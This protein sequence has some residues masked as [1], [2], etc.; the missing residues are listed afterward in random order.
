MEDHFKNKLKNH[1]VDWQKEDLLMD[2]EASLSKKK[3]SSKKAWFLLFPLGLLIL[4]I[5]WGNNYSEQQINSAV[6]KNSKV[7]AEKN[8]ALK[9]AE[10][11]SKIK[12][13]KDINPPIKRPVE[14]NRS[15]DSNETM[16][17]KTTPSEKNLWKTVKNSATKIIAQEKSRDVKKKPIL[18]TE[19]FV[20]VKVINVEK[21]SS[22]SSK[23]N[24]SSDD[25]ILLRKQNSG[26]TSSEDNQDISNEKL[27]THQPITLNN[28]HLIKSSIVHSF[29]PNLSIEH[30]EL[31]ATTS[32]EFKKVQLFF[33]PN[34]SAGFLQRKFSSPFDVNPDE[35]YGEKIRLE[36]AIIHDAASVEIGVLINEKWSVQFGLEYQEMREKFSFDYLLSSD[37]TLTLVEKAY[38]EYNP[39][40][41]S[42]TLFIEGMRPVVTN[43]TRRI[44]HW[45][46]HMYWSIPLNVGRQFIL[47][48]TTINASAGITYA[49]R[50]NFTGRTKRSDIPIVENEN[51]LFKNK[52]GFQFGLSG[53]QKL[54]ENKSLFIKTIFRKSP[55]VKFGDITEKSHLSYSL[56]AGLRFY[57]GR[58]TK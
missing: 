25:H 2:L 53:E 40:I 42:D 24:L 13:V 44:K 4:F 5:G 36:K 39:E 22:F 15:S 26:I 33:E 35:Y 50:H 41:D 55:T 8:D 23:E 14:V 52:I 1:K 31:D 29:I 58:I 10:I 48:E 30:S 51:Y 45:N 16:T 9:S 43:E 17:F 6:A 21:G 20:P 49:I 27:K 47:N 3:K 38:Y 57:L 18:P 37:T 56:G 28:I 12:D 7:N 32:E 54:S 19:N 46:K 11:I 34:I